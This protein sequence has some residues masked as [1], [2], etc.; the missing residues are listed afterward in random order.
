MLASKHSIA[1]FM[2]LALG[3][4]FPIAAMAQVTA[5][6]EIHGVVKDPSGAVVPGAQIEL[7]DQATGITKNAQSDADG[8]F[9]FFSL[10]FGKY[11]VKASAPGFQTA[12]YNDVVVEAGRKADL[13][14]LL[15]VGQPTETITVEAA[16]TRLETTSNQIATTI[17]NSYIQE[18]PLANRDTLAFALLMAGSTGSGATATFNGLPNASMNITLDGINNNSQRF[19]S[20]GTSFYEFAPTRLD[21]M[22]EIT[23]ATTGSGADAAGGG[24]MSIAFVTRRGTNKYHGKFFDQWANTDLNAN[25]FYN[26]MRKPYIPRTVLNQHDAGGNI[27]GPLKVPFVPYFKDRL[28]F[29]F[30]FEAMPRPSTSMYTTSYLIPQAQQGIYT[31]FGTDNQNHTVNV[32]QLAQ[33]AGYS[34][35]VDPT[36]KNILTQINATQASSVWQP[37]TT[38]DLNHQSAQWQYS[39][40]SHSYFPTARLDYQISKNLAWHGSWNL[41]W[42]MNDG[43]PSYPGL[44]Q[45]YN[46]YWIETQ[47]VSN[48]VDW[49]I[50]PTMVLSSNFGIQDNWEVF[51]QEDNIHLWDSQGNRRISLGSGVG[52]LIPNYTPWDRNNPVYNLKEDMNWIKGKH[53]IQIGGA[54]MRTSFWEESWGDAGVQNIGL[55]IGSAD[56]VASVFNTTS[57]PF[58]STNASDVAGAAALYATLTG[59]I[60]DDGITSSR[61]VDEITHQYKDWSP[62][63]QRFARTSLGIYAQ[64]SFQVRPNLTLNY[65]LRWEFSGALNNT[66][67]IDA[68]PD[69][70]N[71]MG[72]SARLFQ[73]GKLDGVSNP[74][75]NLTPYTYHG[76]KVNPAPNF[77]FAWSPNY[78]KG[79]LGKLFGGKT[80]IRSSFGIN[81]YDEGMNSVSNTLSSNPG[82]SQSMWIYPGMTGFD[83]GGLTL[84]STMPTLS[85]FPD[86]F[87][88]PMPESWFYPVYL[89]TTKPELHTPY[90]Q[91]WTFGLQRELAK[92]TVLEIRYVGNRAVHMWHNYNLQ[93]T[94]I[95][96][97]GFLN[98]FK[99]AQNNLAINTANGFKN[100]FSNRNLP[101]EAAMP[102]LDAAFGA[103]GSMPALSTASGYKS[104]SF[105]TTL[106]QGTAATMANNMAGSI[107]YFCRMVGSN[108]G[109]C[110]DNGYNTAGPYPINFFVPN[111]Y[112]SSIYT[113]DDNG[114]SWYHALQIDFKK[115]YGKGLTLNGNYTFSKSMGDINNSSDQTATSQPRTLRDHTLDIMPLFNDRRQTFRAFWTYELPMGP[116]RYFSINNGFINRAIG[117]WTISTS[118][119]AVSGSMGRLSESG[120]YTFNTFADGGV[121]LLNGLTPEKLRAMAGT[122]TAHPVN[123]NFYFLPTYLIG[124]DGRPNPAYIQPCTSPGQICQYVY[125]Y[126][127]WSYTTNM[128][129]RKQTRINERMS[130]LLSAEASNVF[131]HPVFSWSMGSVTSTSF[132]QVS[133]P[134][135]GA[136]SVQLRAEFVW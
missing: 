127:P 100:D 104:S 18:L 83:P 43:T 80:V 107:T 69:M 27:G 47:V 68:T 56:P 52:D 125:L 7:K 23:I 29:F 61:N 64:D 1:L 31:Y 4:L 36:V 77:G 71:L 99:N 89:S 88:F 101:G 66:N 116:G 113:L 103:R 108:F 24:A 121:V 54:L 93:E 48:Q 105:I 58:V 117:G 26:N 90:V 2:A 94:N 34:S 49:T 85:V 67:G 8:T 119:Q 120:R 110:S 133:G 10:T 72:P 65:G 134:S 109:P 41:R 87:A 91:N 124:S 128:S 97:N 96:E 32:L 50:K 45:V 60:G 3:I 132:G 84:Q 118:F 28:F 53:T 22:E 102:I 33:Q 11:Q 95:F 25:S 5:T 131:N 13:P 59:R 123:Q 75:I 74:Q 78:E 126:G 44:S 114:N 40:G 79:L 122:Y 38:S 73:P 106:Q 115:S 12:I 81:Y 30:N 6:G 63:M 39:G 14:V 130:L 35:A 111:P 92:G 37:M 70:A 46:S 82:S 76:D 62:S 55:G 98:D 42:Q 51:Y 135:G 16:A 57:M 21:A 17:P 129:L 15:A 86:K 112:A 9:Q 20:G 19:K 136:R